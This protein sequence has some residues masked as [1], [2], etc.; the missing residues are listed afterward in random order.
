M[1]VGAPRGWHLTER[2]VTLDGDPVSASLFDFALAFHHNASELLA[3]GA[4]R[5]IELERAPRGAELP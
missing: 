2:H 5:I 4:T 1:P 3:R